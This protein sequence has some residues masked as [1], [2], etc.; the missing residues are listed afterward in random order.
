MFKKFSA[1]ENISSTSQIKNSVQRSIYNQIVEQYPLLE[2]AIETILPKKSL[3]VG[4]ASDNIQLLI[5]N[6]EIM[7]F[8]TKDGP[9]YPTLKLLHKYPTMMERMQVDKGAIRFVLG[10]ANIMCPGFTSKG[11][12][13]PDSLAA[14]CPVAIYAEGKENALA[15]GLIKMS[16]EDIR[17]INKGL[18]VENVHYLMDG[19]WQTN[20]L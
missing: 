7:F 5:V 11:G 20:K 18:A 17:K 4:K 13:M 1:E 6:D 14:E 8:S 16:T 12:N 2:N 15:I 19:L 9:F 3:L 10:G